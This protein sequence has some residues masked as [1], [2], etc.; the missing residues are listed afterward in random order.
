MSDEK[1]N[2]SR[3]QIFRYFR[4]E[5]R[6]K[7]DSK[8]NNLIKKKFLKVC[9]KC[10]ET[11][12]KSLPTTK[13]FHYCEMILV[14]NMNLVWFLLKCSGHSVVSI[15]KN[16]NGKETKNDNLIRENFFIC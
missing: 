7:K 2:P 11:K 9:G 1:K 3:A 8:L 14:L 4:I 10:F 13:M 15:K 16:F 12:E 6:N 5:S